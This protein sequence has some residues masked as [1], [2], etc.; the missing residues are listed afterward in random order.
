MRLTAGQSKSRHSD[1]FINN[2]LSDKLDRSQLSDYLLIGV[3]AY[4]ND[5]GGQIVAT[6]GVS[7]KLESEVLQGW[8]YVGRLIC[9]AVEV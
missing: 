3:V 4:T 8:G 6:T 1:R 9:G 7:L 2:I 5:T